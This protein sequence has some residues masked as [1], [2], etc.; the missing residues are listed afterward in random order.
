MWP[1][2]SSRKAEKQRTIDS[3]SAYRLE[4]MLPIRMMSYAIGIE[5]DCYEEI[6][7]VCGAL[8]KRSAAGLEALSE[9]A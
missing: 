6:H 9:C 3:C 8:R 1:I 4:F 7:Q 2:T 5:H